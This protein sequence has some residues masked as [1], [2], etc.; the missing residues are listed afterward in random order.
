MAIIKV[1]YGE[2]GGGGD[3]SVIAEATA[4]NAYSVPYDTGYT[5]DQV[6]AISIASSPAGLRYFGIREGNA[7]TPLEAASVNVTINSS[8]KHIICASTY[9]NVTTLYIKLCN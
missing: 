4:T 7:F 3:L 1:D 5:I 8:T 9:Q 6:R 2:V